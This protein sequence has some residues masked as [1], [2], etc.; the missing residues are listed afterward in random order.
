MLGFLLVSCRKVDRNELQKLQNE[1]LRCC[2]LS[3]ISDAECKLI[4]LEHR[5]RKQLLWL[6]Y[7]II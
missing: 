6:M 3:K 1:I 4:R 2:Y 5:M 7:Y